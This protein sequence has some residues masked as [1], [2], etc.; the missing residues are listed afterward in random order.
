VLCAVWDGLTTREIAA[1]L[2]L[3]MKTIGV[4]RYQVLLKFRAHNVAA[5]L[6]SGVRYQY[7]T[8]SAPPEYKE[9]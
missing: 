4:Y 3:S 7:L 1:R 5:M 9:S 6:A 2:Q 8:I